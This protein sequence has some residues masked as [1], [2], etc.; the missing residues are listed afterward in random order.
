MTIELPRS[1]APRVSVIIPASCNLDLLRACLHS[2]VAYRGPRAIPF[3]TIVVLNEVDAPM[4][5]DLRQSVTGADI[6]SS[7]VN[8]GLAGAGNRARDLAR[9]EFLLL[10]H[11]DAEIE[12]GWMEALVETADARPEA[13]AIGGKVLFPDGR[14][15]NAGMILWRDAHSSPPWVG[16]APPPTAFD[17][18]RAVDYCGTSS[19]LVRASA[20]DAV[21]GLDERFYPVYYVDVDLAMALRKV[22]SVVLYQPESRIRHHHGAS[23]SLRYRLFLS[24]RNRLLFLEKWGTALDEHEPP[25]AGSTAAIERAMAR[26]DAVWQRCQGRATQ[27]APRLPRPAFDPVLQQQRQL[28]RQCAVRKAYLAHLVEQLEKSEGGRPSERSAAAA[29][30]RQPSRR[31]NFWQGAGAR[32]GCALRSMAAV[33]RRPPSKEPR[34]HNN[35]QV[36]G[37]R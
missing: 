16:E 1:A 17:R 24:T 26:A 21:G 32:L 35:G 30:E 14:L 9:G 7:P 28:A 11:D 10:L 3:E 29:G 19:L 13:G 34:S 23:A 6:I 15:Q 18:L 37:S 25:E 5:A 8:L 31:N 12:P 2:L 33:W 20:W 4:E 22:G 36:G 27:R